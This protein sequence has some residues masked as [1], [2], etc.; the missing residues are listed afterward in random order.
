MAG[1]LAGKQVLVTQANDY[2]GPATVERFKAEGANVIA[3]ATDLTEAGAVQALIADSAPIDILV[4][5][6]AAFNQHGHTVEA[7]DDAMFSTMFEVMVYPL[8]RLVRAVAPQMIARNAGKIVVYGSATPLRG[9][10][11]LSAYS[12]A[13]GA[14]VGYVRSMGVELAPHNVQLNLIAQNW[15]ES[16]TYFP[17]KVREHPKFK[18]NMESQVPAGRLARADED[19]SLALFLSTEE[20]DYFVG[21]CIP[22][23]GGWVS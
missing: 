17:S 14:Q 1:R 18:A 7:V 9:M 8:H 21:Q 10:P 22:F 16:E 15:V 12:A 6:L 20:S 3:D 2:M 5:N 4:A 23:A 13:R 11:R 19:V